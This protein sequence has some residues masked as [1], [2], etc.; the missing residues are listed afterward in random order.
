MEHNWEDKVFGFRGA[1][2][3]QANRTSQIRHSGMALVVLDFMDIHKDMM[4]IRTR[5]LQP[6]ILPCIMEAMLLD[7]ETTSS[8]VHTNSNS[9]DL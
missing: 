9:S 1:A 4:H 6:K 3:L 8:L 2:V 7:T 5:L